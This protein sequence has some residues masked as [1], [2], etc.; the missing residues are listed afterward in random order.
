[1]NARWKKLGAALG[2]LAMLGSSLV[3]VVPAIAQGTADLGNYYSYVIQD[4]QL[5]ALVVV[6]ES[7]ATAD[8]VSAIGIAADLG[9]KAVKPAEGGEVTFEVSAPQGQ[10]VEMAIGDS[11]ETFGPYTSY[12]IPILKQGKVKD[13]DGNEYAYEE[14]IQVTVR[15]LKYDTDSDRVESKINSGEYVYTLSFDPAVPGGKGAKIELVGQTYEILKV[16]GTTS[17]VEL[18]ITKAFYNLGVGDV[19]GPVGGYTVKIENI[20]AQGNKVWVTV[21]DPNGNVESGT[22]AEGSSKTFFGG[23]CTVRATD[24]FLGL[25]ND[26][27]VNLEVVGGKVT[28][29]SGEEFELDKNYKVYVTASGDKLSAI[30]L[31]N[32]NAD[33]EFIAGDTLAGPLS[34]VDVSFV[35]LTEPTKTT[36][37]IETSDDVDIGKDATND[38]VIILSS[39]DRILS[40]GT[41]KYAKLYIKIEKVGNDN[42]ITVYKEDLTSKVGTAVNKTT[43]DIAYGDNIL[44]NITIDVNANTI[45]LNEANVVGSSSEVITI[46]YDS[47]SN[48]TDS[49]V[50]NVTYDSTV[51]AKDYAS[52]KEEG[53]ITNGG[54]KFVSISTSNNNAIDDVIKFEI[55]NKQVKAKF[56]VGKPGTATKT[57]AQGEEVEVAGTKIKVSKVEVP[58][59]VTAVPVTGIVAKLDT[60]VTDADK[61]KAL[62]LVGGPVVN[63]LVAELMNAGK[64]PYNITNEQPGAGKGV[65]EVVQDAFKEGKVAIVVA[66]SD[67]QGTA[68]AS[69]I[70]Q[71]YEAYKDELTGK[72]CVVVSGD[73]EKVA[74]GEETPEITTCE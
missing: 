37:T 3:G 6:G 31:K 60:Q 28:L 45:T 64:L 56:R 63:T 58:N 24:V 26:V 54:I 50:K 55:P 41:D 18:G 19:V 49:D 52:S 72:A 32:A 67:R 66:G 61:D 69:W 42:N 38:R 68:I 13:K 12:E 34:Y 39:P 53:F 71:R 65:I 2:T 44:A 43:I 17:E 14:R 40:Y 8:V 73:V 5:N 11:S 21:T 22:V 70:L 1:M 27:K 29:K 46:T 59:A 62:I 57:A 15:D 9:N 51:L 20:D 33:E 4:G 23:K 10:V 35:G 7:A 47:L 25:G 48:M 74:A 16:N 30:E 36:L